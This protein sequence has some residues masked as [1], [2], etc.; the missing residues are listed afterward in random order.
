MRVF[1]L[2]NICELMIIRSTNDG[3]NQFRFVFVNVDSNES[4]QRKKND[5]MS[6]CIASAGEVLAVN[7]SP[8]VSEIFDIS[9]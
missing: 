2:T 1:S 8:P 4:V 3:T 9:G 6:T 7:A 5:A